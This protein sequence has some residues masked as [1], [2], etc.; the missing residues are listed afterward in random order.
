MIIEKTAEKTPVVDENDAIPE[1]IQDT[2]PDLEILA[3][4]LATA[5]DVANGE[6]PEWERDPTLA[7][8]RPDLDALEPD[9]VDMSGVWNRA[10]GLW[11]INKIHFSMTGQ[12]QSTLDNYLEM[13]NANSRCASPGLVLA[14]GLPYPLRVRHRPGWP[15]GE[16]IRRACR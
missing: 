16:S 13:D 12:G 7:Q 15:I 11:G 6:V 3:P 9:P 10:S 5:A 14:T 1:L 8:L 4:D 2:L